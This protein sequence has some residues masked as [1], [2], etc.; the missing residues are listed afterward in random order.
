MYRLPKIFLWRRALPEAGYE[1]LSF[2][3]RKKV[4][5]THGAAFWLSVLGPVFVVLNLWQGY[6]GLALINL[7]TSAVG[8]VSLFLGK[9]GH[10]RL[11][12]AMIVIVAPAFFFLSALL[13]RNAMEYTLLL[14]M[15][16]AI[17]MFDRWPIRF[18]L[19]LAN[20]AGFLFVRLWQ[21]GMPVEEG[22]P[23]ARYGINLVIFVGCY[24]TVLEIFRVIN[25]NYWSDVEERN[26]A[27]RERTQEL[28]VA[29]QAKERLF[30]I[31]AHDLRGPVG[32]LK[33]TMELMAEKQMTPEVFEFLSERLRREVN[34]AY[35]CL[36]TLL[37]WSAGQLG[38][39]QATPRVLALRD[40]VRRGV[41]LLAASA[42][43]KQIVLEN[44]VPPEVR[45]RADEDQLL[46]V[47]RNLI[48]NALKFTPAGGQV[49]I[50]ALREEEGF[51]RVEVA[52][53]GVG[54]SEEKVN[55]LFEYGRAASTSGT[56]NERGLGLGLQICCDFV[57]QQGGT[58]AVES[59]EGE[60]SIFSFTLP[61]AE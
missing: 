53:T 18:G 48:S 42:A 31:V 11:A 54:I 12:A 43:N 16:G 59:T 8:L 17:F 3:D 19:A 41:A 57:Q 1:Q 33:M 37:S 29:N 60:G 32:N 30:S 38:M 20:G 14:G 44:E 26:T 55:A 27:L 46:T 58:L 61:V 25:M 6:S 7:C 5:I 2:S 36:D 21:F 47:L 22:M 34:S 52:D 15:M 13:Y 4:H 40:V 9:H 51:W 28:K 50:G 24:L 23:V 10:Y 45:V 39:I 35:D 49:R 56:E